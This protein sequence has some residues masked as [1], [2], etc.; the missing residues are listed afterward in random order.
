MKAWVIKSE[1]RYVSGLFRITSSLNKANFYPTKKEA[2]QCCCKS[3]IVIPVEI[4]LIKKR[5]KK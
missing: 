2:E 5:K 3:E 4:K 1:G